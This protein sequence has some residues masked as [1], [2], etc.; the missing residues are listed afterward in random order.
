[1]STVPG[2]LFVP[3]LR[4]RMGDWIYYVCFM[5][6]T[7]ISARVV[8]AEEIHKAKRL[9]ELIQR[10]LTDR[11]EDIAEYLVSEQQRLFNA[12]VL[13]VYGGQPDWYDLRIGSN[14]LLK[15][16]QLPAYIS[17][18]VGVLRLTGREQLFALDGQHRVAGIRAAVRSKQGK[19]S[20][21]P[22]EE[23]ACIF[24][25]HKKTVSGMRRT[26]RLFTTLN[27]HAKPVSL[28]EIIAL[29]EDDLAAIVTRSI[30]EEAGMMRADK[31]SFSKSRAMTGDTSN[32]TNVTTLYTCHSLFL[33]RGRKAAE[34]RKYRLRRPNDAT[35]RC[36]VKEAK[37][38]WNS[39]QAG[40][41]PLDDVS[42]ERKMASV[43][44]NERGGHLLF[45]PI[46]LEIAIDAISRAIAW[47]ELTPDQAISR[48]RRVPMKLNQAPWKGLIWT[49]S[50][51][52]TAKGR[53]ALARDLV[54]YMM[55][56]RFWSS[57]QREES[58]MVRLRGRLASAMNR[59]PEEVSLPTIRH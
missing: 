46:G 58:A 51:M 12:L 49:E 41:R 39:L 59:Q 15:S 47:H 9:R 31:V 6:M 48:I 14:E 11:A 52:D 34:W 2:K 28:A 32:I 13:G 27:R 3:A 45:R 43:F 37:S 30:L 19:E 8:V 35:I 21:L 20:G 23:V 44:R 25:G 38:L 53:K 26:R 54:L 29:D 57:R 36:S 1:M 5:R 16:D 4:A 42:G 7:D 24:V 17:G 18:S 33:G 10:E 50:G 56:C 40:F 55:G 22:D